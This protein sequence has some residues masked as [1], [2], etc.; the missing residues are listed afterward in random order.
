ML[1]KKHVSFFLIGLFLGVGLGRPSCGAEVTAR[2]NLEIPDYLSKSARKRVEAVVKIFQEAR[3]GGS[4]SID[5]AIRELKKVDAKKSSRCHLLPYYLGLAYQIKKDF[6]RAKTELSR[7]VEQRAAFFEALTLLAE[8]HL[9]LKEYSSAERRFDQALEFSKYIPAFD[10]KVRMLI[11][12]GRFEEAQ[13]A[14]LKAQQLDKNPARETLLRRVD[15]TLRPGWGDTHSAKTSHYEVKS[16]V[17]A[18]FSEEIG[19][20]SEL[21]RERFEALF[22]K[23]DDFGEDRLDA[24]W[25]YDSKVSFP[26]KKSVYGGYYDETFHRVSLYRQED[27]SKTLSVLFHLL[28]HQYVRDE[29][30]AVPCWL[31]EGLAEYF[32]LYKIVESKKGDI[33]VSQSDAHF[34]EKIKYINTRKEQHLMTPEKLAELTR[35]QVENR[36]LGEFFTVQSWIHWYFLLEGAKG[37]KSKRGKFRMSGNLFHKKVGDYLA[38]LKQGGDLD[39]AYKTTLGKIPEKM[40]ERF[41]AE[42]TRYVLR[43]KGG[44]G[45]S[46]ADNVAKFRNTLRDCI[47]K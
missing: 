9:A 8:V 30:A 29:M 4:K 11:L 5:R 46:G 19:R 22:S 23:E 3:R 15:E 44:P 36:L 14:C 34:C 20:F 7:A 31:D 41:F 25:V 26:K 6:A 37:K 2:G 35:T 18:E 17:S 40:Y 33:P 38:R 24:I 12:Q 27:L 28:F 32:G 43:K 13:K 42:F 45:A 21:I 1:L 47:R 39:R 10:G 16:N